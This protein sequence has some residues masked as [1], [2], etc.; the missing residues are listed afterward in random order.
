LKHPYQRPHRFIH[1][2]IGTEND[3]YVQSREHAFRQNRK[4]ITTPERARHKKSGR[5]MMPL[6]FIAASSKNGPLFEFIAG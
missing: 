2:S 1:P 4:E 6:S 5:R 3:L